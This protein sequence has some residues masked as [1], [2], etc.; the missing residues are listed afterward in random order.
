MN[1]R[2]TLVIGASLKP[3]RYAYKAVEA[4]RRS[5]Y[6]V[7][8]IGLREGYI[9]DVPVSREMPL[10][11]TVDTVTLYVGAER[12]VAYYDYLAKLRPGRVI[13]NPGAEND[14]LAVKMSEMGV[15]VI[16]ACTLVMLA[17]GQY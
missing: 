13:F 12:Q 14:E 4:L 3:W 6:P 8:A 16:E 5:G 7:I 2:V 15:E 17:T 11:R 1:G 9:G 10:D